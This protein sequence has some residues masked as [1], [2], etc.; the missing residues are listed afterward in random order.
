MQTASLDCFLNQA[1]IESLFSYFSLA[2]NVTTFICLCLSLFLSL[3]TQIMPL[4]NSIWSTR[5][6]RRQKRYFLCVIFPELKLRVN[7][8]GSSSSSKGTYSA[9][10]VEQGRKDLFLNFQ[11]CWFFLYLENKIKVQVRRNGM[12]IN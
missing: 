7:S 9:K 8:S 11:S 3:C 6:R 5:C 1:T 12:K 2:K 10:S 4:I